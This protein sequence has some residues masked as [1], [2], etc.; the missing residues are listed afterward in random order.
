MLCVP[1]KTGVHRK[2][3]ISCQINNCFALRVSGEYGCLSIIQMNTA[4][5]IYKIVHTGAKTKF[6][7]FK[8]G[9]FNDAN[10][11]LSEL[12]TVAPIM[13]PTAKNTIAKM[14]IFIIIPL[15]KN[16]KIYLCARSSMD[17]A[18]ASEA[19]HM[20]STPVGRV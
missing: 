16:G 15:I 11:R 6:G 8:K 19:E 4:S 10:H 5:D 1:K 3:K 17:R 12:L 20:G 2:F 14:I 18:S 13:I 7:G 9:L